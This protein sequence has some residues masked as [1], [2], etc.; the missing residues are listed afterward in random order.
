VGK[1]LL[2]SRDGENF[3]YSVVRNVD[4][5]NATLRA[6]SDGGADEDIGYGLFGW[7][8]GTD[9][10]FLWECKGITRGNPI[11]SYRAEGYGPLPTFVFD[12]LPSLPGNSNL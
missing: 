2:S 11:Q 12:T 10:N 9:Q 8:L 1:D 5:K 3:H 4:R 7:V 6:V